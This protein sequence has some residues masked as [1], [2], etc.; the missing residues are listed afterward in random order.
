MPLIGILRCNPFPFPPERT[1]SLQ[2]VFASSN[3]VNIVNLNDDVFFCGATDI[4]R[5][6][7]HE[8][9][10]QPSVV[11]LFPT[12]NSWGLKCYGSGSFLLQ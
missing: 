11:H 7:C 2:L 9:G 4:F 12:S 1:I 8:N 6:F 5:R 10:L 3:Y